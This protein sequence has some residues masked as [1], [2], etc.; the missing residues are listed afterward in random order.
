MLV[1]HEHDKRE[2]PCAGLLMQ[3]FGLTAA[4]ARVAVA[5]ATG[6]TVQDY[7][8]QHGLSP[9]TVRSQIKATFAK[10]GI[11]RQAD[12]VRIVLAMGD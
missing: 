5:V 2:P 8:L 3:V 4:E 10:A 9:E 11:N 12:L 1:V 7:A 6:V